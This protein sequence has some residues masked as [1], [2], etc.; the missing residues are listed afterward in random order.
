[1]IGLL[2]VPGTR[3]RIVKKRRDLRRLLVSELSTPTRDGQLTTRDLDVQRHGV[4]RL[5]LE[6]LQMAPYR[7]DVAAQQR[8]GQRASMP[9]RSALASACRA[10]GA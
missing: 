10:N 5:F 7:A 3:R 2:G 1:M 9:S 4:W 6:N 8:T